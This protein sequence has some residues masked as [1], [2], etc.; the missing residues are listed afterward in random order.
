MPGAVLGRDAELSVVEAFLAGLSSGPSALVLAGPAGMGKT[1]VLREGAERAVGLGYTVLR[2]SPTPSDMR[3]VFAGLADLLSSRLDS[4][5]PEL[6]APQQRALGAALLLRD[7]SATPPEPHVI[8]AAFRSAMLLL[9]TQAP[10]VVSID[11]V[12][13]LDGPTALAAGFAFRRLVGEHVGLLLAQRTDGFDGELPLEL[14]RTRMTA[15][16]LP[17]GGLSLGAMH[18]MLHSRLGLSLSHQTLVR[19]HAE[20]A[21]NPFIALEIARALRR[22]GIVRVASGSLPVLETLNDLVG[23][24]LRELAAP[25][26]NAL[27]VVAMLPDA[28]MS[29]CLAAGVSAGDLDAAVLAGVVEVESGRVRFSH[30]LLASAVLGAIPPG[31]RRELHALAAESAIDAEERARHLALATDGPSAAITA[32]LDDAATEAQ[33]RGAP[34]TAAELLE[35]SVSKTPDDRADDRHQ[36]MIRAGTQLVLAGETR[37]AAAVFRQVADA[38]PPGSRRAEALALLG[39]NEEDD[40]ETSVALLEEALAEVGDSPA[41]NATFRM[42]LCDIWAILGENKRARAEIEVALAHAEN[43]GNATLLA[44]VLAQTFYFNWDAGRAVDES[45]LDRALDL[46]RELDSFGQLGLPSMWAGLYYQA[47]G[48]LDEAQQVLE[49][50]L[51]RAQG[52]GVEYTQSDVLLRLSLL[53]TK[54]GDPRRGAELA[55]EG[56]DIAEQLDL[57]Q[58]TSAL[59]YGCGRAA[60]QAGES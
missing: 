22:R 15:E 39:W 28:P 25:V 14:G 52:E 43:A 1:T 53:A 29:R 6:P 27:G 4:V 38:A 57:D 50:A 33:Q 44:S 8:A 34:S 26:M 35:L 58:L 54:K 23:E 31:R 59:L 16:S 49:R 12:Q 3:L 41:L 21:G 30:P 48:R 42:F 60:L 45:L 20:S 19:V 51:A 17:L 7:A 55:R 46:E 5:L 2:T 10:V 36:R 40:F 24:R 37:A 18:R 56:L 32:E 47:T 9:A 11:D 13:W